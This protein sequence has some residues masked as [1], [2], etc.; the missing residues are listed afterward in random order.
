M[1]TTHRLSAQGSPPS[2]SAWLAALIVSAALF[3]TPAAAHTPPRAE[4]PVI[5]AQLE[6]A[7]AAPAAAIDPE[8][9]S[10]VE[11]VKGIV[12]AGK[13]GKWLVLVMFALKLVISALR[14]VAKRQLPEGKF[15]TFITGRVAGWLLNFGGSQIGAF[16]LAASTGTLTV[17]TAIALI[18]SGLMVSLA[19]AGTRELVNDVKPA[20]AAGLAAAASPGPTLGA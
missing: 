3:A 9:A 18:T 2:P 11:A 16:T 12:G 5:S 17:D 14:W 6:A 1:K 15:K 19:A 7:P 13:A 10:T 20:Q 4:L 8:L